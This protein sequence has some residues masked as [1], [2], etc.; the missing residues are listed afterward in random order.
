MNRPSAAVT[1]AAFSRV[2]NR[3]ASAGG[4]RRAPPQVSQGVYARYFES[5]TRTCI[6]YAF[7]S[8]HLKKRATPYHVPGHERRQFFHCDSP[9][10]THRLWGAVS[11]FHGTSSG[12]PRLS[13]YSTRSS[14][15]SL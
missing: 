5:S 10:S 11:A 3:H 6:L 7:V 8:S 1:S 13:A 12:M 15:H 14:W 4:F 9:S 2:P